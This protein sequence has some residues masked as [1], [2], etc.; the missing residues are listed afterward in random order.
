MDHVVAIRLGGRSTKDNLVTC[1]WQCNQQKRDS[2][3]VDFLLS[4]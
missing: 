1:C 4:K 2:N 3:I